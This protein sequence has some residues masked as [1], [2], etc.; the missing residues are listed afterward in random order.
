MTKHVYRKINSD[1]RPSWSDLVAAG[2]SKT[3]PGVGF[4]RHYHDGAEYWLIFGGRAR[5]QVGTD[6]F[7]VEPTDIVCT[8]EGVEHDIL[9]IDGTLDMFYLATAVKPG[10]RPGHLH[11]GDDYD[12]VIESMTEE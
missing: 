4:D 9:A 6:I 2:S 1:D 12:H 5:V 8:P 10:G 3:P 7:V 11:R